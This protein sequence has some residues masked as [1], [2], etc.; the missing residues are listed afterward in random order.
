[1]SAREAICTMWINGKGV[2][3]E[4]IRRILSLEITFS[5][6]K[7]SSGSI[8]FRDTDFSIFDSRLFRK[9]QALHFFMGWLNE[10]L[11]AGPFVVK[12]YSISAP[13]NG[14]PVLTVKFQDL[15]HKMNEKQKR[16]RHTGKPTDI[17]K[18]IAKEHGLGYTIS[19]VEGLEFTDDF[20]LIQASISDAALLQR[21]ADRY[22]YVWGVDGGNLYFQLPAEKQSRKKLSPPVLSYRINDASL[23]SFSPEMKYSSGGK[24]KGAAHKL[25]NIDFL[26]DGKL[27]DG[28]ANALGITE[29]ERKRLYDENPHDVKEA[30]LIE[31]SIAKGIKSSLGEGATSFYH[32]AVDSAERLISWL[33]D[34]GYVTNAEAAAANKNVN[35]GSKLVRPIDGTTEVEYT[36]D[37]EELEQGCVSGACTPFDTAEAE[38]RTLGNKYRAS[39]IITGEAIPSIGSMLYA[40]GSKVTLLGLGVFLSGEYLIKEVRQSFSSQAATFSTNLIVYRSKFLPGSKAKSSALEVEQKVQNGLMPP[41]QYGGSSDLSARGGGGPIREIEKAIDSYQEGGSFSSNLVDWEEEI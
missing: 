40:P 5:Q 23:M 37:L 10:A 19:S 13:S 1:M 22:G 39:E 11:P 17:L 21:L 36:D 38:R 16:R 31:E 14:N 29:D 8:V 41:Q 25:S 12:S 28:L 24:R 15:S 20:P 18:K 4:L 3:P 7:A 35:R 9:G 2:S 27:T 32:E 26:N 33:A 34:T 30:V 6:K